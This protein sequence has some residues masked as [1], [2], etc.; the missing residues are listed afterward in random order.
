MDAS[1]TP[2]AAQPPDPET[3]LPPGHGPMPLTVCPTPDMARPTPVAPAFED[4][5]VATG[6]H[7]ARP[8]FEDGTLAGVG[9]ETAGPSG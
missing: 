4:G 7:P 1:P 3:E 5:T 9:P 6:S 8:A 2:A